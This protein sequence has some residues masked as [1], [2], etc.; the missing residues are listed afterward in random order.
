MFATLSADL[1]YA[2]R[3][4]VARPLFALVAIGSLALGIGVNTAMFSLFEQVVLRPLPVHEPARLV[5]LS[6]PGIKAGS[7]SSD[8]TG[9]RDDIL[10]HPM[11]RDLQAQLPP[12]LAGIAGHRAMPVTFGWQQQV[13]DGRALL[14]SGNYFELLGLRPALGRLLAADDDR[15]GAA[16][17]V[18]LSHDYWMDR[19]GGRPEVIGQSLRINDQTLTVVGVG[20]VGF[21]GTTVG[22]RPEVFA[23]LRLAPR[24]QQRGGFGLEDRRSYWVYAFGRLAPGSGI[25]EAQA[26]LNQ[27]YA[28][29]LQEIELPLHADLE[30]GARAEFAS[31]RL[32]LAPGARGQSTTAASIGRPLGLLLG[33]AA[34]VLLIACLN[35]ANLLLA[36]GAARAGEFAI[37][38][39][40]GASRGRLL[41]QLLLESLLIALL[42]ALASLPLAAAATAGL[43]GWLP[44]VAARAFDGALSVEALQ[45]TV[46]VAALT[47]LLFGLFPALQLAR[48]APIAALRGETGQAGSRGGNRFRAGLATAQIAFSMASLVLAGLFGKSLANIAG[49]DLGMRVES[50]AVMAIAPARRGYDDARATAL[51]DRLEQELAGLPG[52]TAVATS[53]VPLLANSDWSSNVS[54]EGFASSADDTSTSYNRIGVG[55]FDTLGIPLLAGR[56]FALTDNEGAAKVAIVNRSFVE[57]YGLP[58]NPVG[59][60]M[61]VGSSEQL[62]IEIVGLVADSK[63]NDVRRRPVPLFFLPRRQDSAL[64]MNFYVRSALPP[65]TLLPQLAA[66]VARLDPD[67]PVAPRTLPQDIAMT[68]V[69]E[70][71]VGVLSA[72]FALLSTLLAALGLYGLL[73]YTLSQR[74]REIGLRLALGAAPRRLAAML[75]GQVGRMTVVGGLI[76]FAIAFAAGRAAQS[77]LFGLE[78]HDPV[79][80]AAAA[81][82]LGLVALAS[83]A[84]PARRASRIDPMTALRHD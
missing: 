20:P 69:T 70:R 42:G 30:P 6:A 82:V 33:V 53:Q 12:Q 31:R 61:A 43:L 24:L 64:T 28:R 13:A 11:F 66:A 27:P 15:E 19:L 67:L 18:V 75:L 79:V 72:A 84:V 63:Y 16:A 46:L 22:S 26:A 34:L 73:S 51:Y 83:G 7:T 14:V 41:R 8:N 48:A 23:P 2:V 52:V 32:L 1:R 21:R 81:G 25:A 47:V 49:E 17:V 4:L 40:I 76:G 71:A 44:P 9:P 59:R 65:E 29:L 3:G 37:R 62:D 80:F 68:I 74:T 56:D 58:D 54:V 5:N 45:F 78:S 60:R 36:R 57:R 55:F 77:L 35:I 38:A 50:L 39:S 10:S